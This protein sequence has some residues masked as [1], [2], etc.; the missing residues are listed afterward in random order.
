[1]TIQRKNYYQQSA[2]LIC[3]ILLAAKL[4]GCASDKAVDESVS[5]TT[6]ITDI[7]LNDNPESVT[8]TIRA[9]KYL[10]YSSLTQ[11]SPKGVLFQFPD[12]ILDNIS[13]VYTPPENEVVDFIEVHD[14]AE[15]Q[16][17]KSVLFIALKNDSVYDVE[18]VG[19]GLKISFPKPVAA[20]E[21]SETQEEPTAAAAPQPEMVTIS[22]P[23]ATQ[24]EAVKASTRKNGVIVDVKADGAVKDYESFTLNSPPRIVFDMYN[25][26]S[27]YNAQQDIA[28]AS[29]WVHRIRHFG[30][31]EKVRLV[32]DTHE[33]YLSDYSAS[34]TSNG[35]S[36]QVG[37][38][39]VGLTE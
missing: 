28:V 18:P 37:D 31:P 8:I 36:I 11:V 21:D 30:Y 24:L 26:K 4:S 6:H 17:T 32:I 5:E 33:D 38:F 7:V 10:L 19:D 23:T 13:P 29:K 14:K 12:T 25:L 3:L 27:P 39:P 1:M 16:T 35:L 20:P 22:V 34:P 9:D 15:A 2:L